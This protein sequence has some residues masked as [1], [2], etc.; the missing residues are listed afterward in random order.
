MM[1]ILTVLTFTAGPGDFDFLLGK[2]WQV[3][4]RVLIERLV[5]AEEWT[6]FEAVLDEVRPIAN[7]LG[8]V[9]RFTAD[10][11]GP[12]EGNSIRLYDPRTE[13][14]AIWWVDSRNPELRFQVEGRFENGR[15]EF[16]GEEVYRGRAVKMRFLWKDIT[17]TSATWEQAYL[18]EGTREWETNWIMTFTRIP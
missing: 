10:W 17:S 3:H 2:R 9:D 14:W 11:N 12:F 13:R 7:G 18:D 6:E 8:N 5:G 1:L 4:N 15:G 16:F